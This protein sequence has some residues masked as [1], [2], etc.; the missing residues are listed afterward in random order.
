MLVYNDCWKFKENQNTGILT[1][2]LKIIRTVN[3]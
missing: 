3:Q 2:E 1:F